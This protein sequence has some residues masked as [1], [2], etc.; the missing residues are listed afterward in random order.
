[1]R[2][3]QLRYFVGVAQAGSF[4]KASREL[5]IAQPALSNQISSLEE[6]LGVELLIRHSRG[7]DLTP[8]GANLLKR[9]I[10]IIGLVDSTTAS[11]TEYRQAAPIDVNIGLPTTTTGIMTLPLLE[12]IRRSHP[13]INLHIVEGMTGHLEKWLEQDDIGAAVLFAMPAHGNMSVRLIGHE[14]LVVVGHMR[15][16]LE[17]R[18][19][20]TF[21]E[22]AGLPLIH[23]TRAHQLR[24]MLDSMASRIKRPLDYVA[25]IDS[26]AQINLMVR[27]GSGYTILPKRYAASGWTGPDVHMWEL[28]TAPDEEDM[29]HDIGI[30]LVS[31]PSFDRESFSG[32]LLS[33]MEATIRD[34][35]RSGQWLGATLA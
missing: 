18:T 15:E 10:E 23:S 32:S 27:A 33:D 1:M 35:I 8:A 12:A 28:E 29:G 7:V 14:R 26:L 2:L 19:G 11:M 17:G 30:R 24:R 13:H 22:A 5:H 16:D 9:S 6:G 3:R 34:L 20:M 31:S 21:C 4:T 25:E